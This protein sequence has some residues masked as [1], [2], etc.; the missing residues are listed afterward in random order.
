MSGYAKDLFVLV[1]DSSMEQAFKGLLARHRRPGSRQIG[2]DIEVHPQRDPG[3]RTH[4]VSL[5]RP[6]IKSHQY[7][8]VVFDCQGCG[9]ESLGREK[10]QQ[11]VQEGLERNGWKDRCK[12]IVIEPELENWVWAPSGK[13][14]EVLGWGNDFDALRQWLRACKLWAD[15]DLKPSDPKRAMEKALRRKRVKRSSA[16]FK[17][18]ARISQPEACTDPAFVE[19]RETLQAWFPSKNHLWD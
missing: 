9:G 11:N 1:A 13:I 7:V 8:L 18:I 16:L 3:C 6:R 14:A 17:K 19:L 2:Y 5:L 10:L 4:A 12:V 15:G